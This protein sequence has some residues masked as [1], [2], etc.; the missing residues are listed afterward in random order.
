MRYITI[1][2]S[3]LVR[4]IQKSIKNIGTRGRITM[5]NEKKNKANGIKSSICPKCGHDSLELLQSDEY[6]C[7][8]CRTHFKLSNISQEEMIEWFVI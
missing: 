4:S 3:L 2:W 7:K 5:A 6:G 1:L 8:N